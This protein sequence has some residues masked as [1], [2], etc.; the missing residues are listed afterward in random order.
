MTEGLINEHGHPLVEVEVSGS[1]TTVKLSAL[2]DSGFDGELCL[3]IEVAVPLGLELVAVQTVEFADGSTKKELVF[4]GRLRWEGELRRTQVYL[5][6]SEQALVGAGL[7]IDR[8]VT[9]DF[10]SGVVR[11]EK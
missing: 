7:L 11:I 4:D 2:L 1:R 9:L 8:L 3:P 5:T 10:R 6:A